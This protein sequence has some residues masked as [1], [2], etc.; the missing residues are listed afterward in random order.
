M[1]GITGQ[2]ISFGG[3]TGFFCPAA[4]A[5]LSAMVAAMASLKHFIEAIVQFPFRIIHTPLMALRILHTNDFHGKLTPEMAHQI[6]EFKR[7]RDA[8]YYD[9]GD[10]IRSGNLAMPSKPEEAWTLLRSAGC[11]ASVLGNRES[12]PLAKGLRAKTAGSQHPILVANLFDR[13]GRRPYAP[14]QLFERQGRRIAVIGVMVPMITAKMA[15]APLSNY[16]WTDP[17]DAARDQVGA[18]PPVDLIIALTHIGFKNDTLLAE[19]VPSLNIIL[20]GHSHTVLESPIEH[21]STWICQTGSHGRYI[22]DYEW[23]WESK[24]LSGGLIPLS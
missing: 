12:H 9:C 8:L 5:A 16:L 3:G 19:A 20:G 21:R 7:E 6:G 4:T 14:F 23:D 13:K 24:S 22:G 15:S 2:A 11:D 1:A 10:C 17:I 18:L